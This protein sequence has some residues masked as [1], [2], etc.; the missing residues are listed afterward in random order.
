MDFIIADNE[1]I[2]KFKIIM[3]PKTIKQ[4]LISIVKQKQ[5]WLIA[6]YSAFV[7]IFLEYLSENEGKIFLELNGFSSQFS[8]Y[9]ITLGWLGFAVGCPILGFISDYLKVRK[10]IMIAAAALCLIGLSTIIYFPISKSILIVGFLMLGMGAAGISIGFTII[11]EHCHK[12]YLSV[13]LGFNNTMVGLVS[14]VNAPAIGLLLDSHKQ[15][16]ELSLSDYNYAFSILIIIMAAVI[17]FSIYFIKET[18][19]RSTKDFTIIT[20]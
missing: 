11:A 5:I 3:K 20:K 1:Q 13:G 19:C 18:Y 17:F 7:Y 2:G 8:S 15:Q 12:Y 6:L 9:M 16:A 4:N 14:A 10:P